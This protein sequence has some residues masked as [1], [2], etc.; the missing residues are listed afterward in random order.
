MELLLCVVQK[1]VVSEIW[2]P[3]QQVR[4][5]R[6]GGGSNGREGRRMAQVYPC[7][8]GGEALRLVVLRWP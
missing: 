7:L 3:A 8:V 1:L 5:C 6:E 2:G 4:E